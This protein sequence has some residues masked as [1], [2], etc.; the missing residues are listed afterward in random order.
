MSPEIFDPGLS[1]LAFLPQVIVADVLDQ[2]VI[3][4]LAVAVE[5]VW[6]CVWTLL[7]S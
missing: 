2:G 3:I 1:S 5:A 7:T 6:R 4:L